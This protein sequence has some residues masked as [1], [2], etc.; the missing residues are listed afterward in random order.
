MAGMLVT[1]TDVRDALVRLIRIGAL[2]SV[3][4]AIHVLTLML[5]W[6]S[7]L[8]DNVVV[9]GIQGFVLSWSFTL[10][11]LAGALAGGAGVL[12]SL[13]SNVKMLRF[14]VPSLAIAGSALA[15]LSPLYVLLH[16][17]PSLNIQFRPEVGAIAALFTGVA[18]AGGGFISAMIGFVVLR[19]SS[20]PSASPA[21]AYAPVQTTAYEVQQE[22]A[23][24]Y[25]EPSLSREEEVFEELLRQEE[26]EIGSAT[27]PVPVQAPSLSPTAA[28]PQRPQAAT[29][30][31]AICSETIPVGSLRFC[32]SC[33]AP[34]HRECVETWRDI[35][36]KCPN[37]GA[38]LI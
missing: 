1:G 27:Q 28:Q 4:G 7:L 35:G 2:I 23:Q 34:M 3:L 25:E 12:A 36:G 5:D 21:M 8:N 14:T 24:G 9:R 16:H 18:M 30:E 10:S 11:L 20:S 22:F 31:C 19:P 29:Q 33:G 37:C 26:V 6:A 38:P 17:L 13:S 15:I 32:N